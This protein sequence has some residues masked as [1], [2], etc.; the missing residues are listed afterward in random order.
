MALTEV[1]IK[2]AR[3]WVRESQAITA[4][5]YASQF[6]I[7]SKQDELLRV[8]EIPTATNSA[9]FMKALDTY[10]SLPTDFDVAPTEGVTIVDPMI[11]GEVIEGTYR[12]VYSRLY[13]INDRKSGT[14]KYLIVQVLRLGFVTSVDAGVIGKCPSD[15]IF[16]KCR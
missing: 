16:F 9:L 10:G 8:F 1:Q 2:T 12:H 3:E 14:P 7:V 6:G 4:Y 11:N 13:T 5:Q 15:L